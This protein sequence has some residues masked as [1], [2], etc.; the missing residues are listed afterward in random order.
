MP[1]YVDT[2]VRIKLVRCTERKDIK[3]L[4]VWA[5]GVYPFEREN[6]EIEMVLFVP[7][8]LQ[9]RDSETQA[10]F[11]QN[12]FYSFLFCNV[13][14][15]WFL[16]MPCYVDTIVRIK[17]V[18]CT[19]RKNIKS[20][21]VWAIGVYPFER[22]NNEIEMVL[23]VPLALQNRDSET[24][25]IFE[26]NNFYSVGGKIV[27][28]YYGGSSGLR[29]CLIKY[30]TVAI[31]TWVVLLKATGS[32]KCSLKVSL[33][34]V[35]Q[36]SSRIAE[37]DENAVVDVLVEDYAGQD[38][39]FI[40]KIAFPHS[41]SRF[42]KLMTMIPTDDGGSPEFDNTARSK[43]LLTHRNIAKNSKEISKAE[44]SSLVGSDSIVNEQ[45]PDLS[46]NNISQLKRS[47]TERVDDPINALDD[48]NCNDLHP[49]EINS[50]GTVH[51]GEAEDSSGLHNS[52][53]SVID[54]E[55]NAERTLAEV[56][57]LVGSDSIVNEQ[58]PDLSSNNISQLKRSRTERVDDPINALDD[59]NC[60]DLHPDEI[61]S[62]G[63]VHSGEAEDSSG[64]H[65]SAAS[66]ID[67]EKK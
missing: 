36:E 55:K 45:Q 3:S 20:L 29:F 54:N 31:S 38:Y 30:M 65:N 6:N 59:I 35:P 9:N 58:Q 48:I 19:E 2:I 32:N 37:D 57:S 53:A 27:P 43:L 33:L 26:Q 28:G 46:S 64:L 42:A 21:M 4:M 49:D 18:R 41:N 66:V 22:E 40:V 8:A 13:T 47:R 62:M 39:S 56:S 14:E 51:S 52:A 34:G 15:S 12:N 44:V 5:I 63:T 1:C 24:Q 23:F 16:T 7:L 25:A 10:I 67:N 61:N 17:L 50:M 11:E 60:N